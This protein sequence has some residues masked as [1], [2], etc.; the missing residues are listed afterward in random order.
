[1]SAV[2]WECPFCFGENGA[3]RERCALAHCKQAPAAPIV[4]INGT[5]WSDLYEQYDAANAALRAAGD[6][7]RNACPNGRDYYVQPSGTMDAA[8]DQHWDRTKRLEGIRAEIEYILMK[9]SEQ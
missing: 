7:L 9:V 5:G 8:Q 2:E 4:H 1:M 6:A 3:H